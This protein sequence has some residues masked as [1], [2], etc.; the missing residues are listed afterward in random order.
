[1]AGR[2]VALPLGPRFHDRAYGSATLDGADSGNLPASSD[3]VEHSAPVLAPPAA[4][5]EWNIDDW[6]KD[7]AVRNAAAGTRSLGPQ[8]IDGL[9]DLVRSPRTGAN[10][11]DVV[12]P[13]GVGVRNRP[14]KAVLEPFLST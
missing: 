3:R 11:P 2:E 12:D 13:L 10:E 6:S 4:A 9:N 14:P 5:S 8:V 7:Q 1:M